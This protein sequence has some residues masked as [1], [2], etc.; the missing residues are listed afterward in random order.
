VECSSTLRSAIVEF[1]DYIANE[2]LAVKIQFEIPENESKAIE[3]DFD[4]E[5][6]RIYI[7]KKR[8]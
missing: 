4:G 7:L 8:K 5:K 3:D 6:V 1:H 2:T